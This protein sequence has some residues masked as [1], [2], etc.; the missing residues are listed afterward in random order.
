MDGEEKRERE[1]RW[2]PM[3]QGEGGRRGSDLGLR[4]EQTIQNSAD[5]SC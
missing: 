3:G 2:G 1:G 5:T 4:F